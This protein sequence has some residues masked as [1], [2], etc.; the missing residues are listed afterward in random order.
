MALSDWFHEQLSVFICALISYLRHLL[1]VKQTLDGTWYKYIWLCRQMFQNESDFQ[2][3][4]IVYNCSRSFKAIAGISPTVVTLSMYFKNKPNY[5]I[6]KVIQ[7][8]RQMHQK[9]KSIMHRVDR[10]MRPMWNVLLLRMF[11]LLFDKKRI[12]NTLSA[13]LMQ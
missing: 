11:I 6:Y 1:S 3:Q 13:L 5:M 4:T 7:S 12:V 9:R 2:Y 8:F 10:A